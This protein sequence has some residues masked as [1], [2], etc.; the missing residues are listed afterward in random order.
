MNFWKL[1]VI[2]KCLNRDFKRLKGFQ[3]LLAVHLFTPI[4]P[5]KFPFRLLRKQK[6]FGGLIIYSTF[7]EQYVKT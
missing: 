6:I 1:K 5:P 3:G 2:G 7:V 4:H